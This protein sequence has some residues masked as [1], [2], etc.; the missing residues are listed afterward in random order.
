MIEMIVIHRNKL[1]QKYV[2]QKFYVQMDRQSK[3][4]SVRLIHLNRPIADDGGMSAS[5]TRRRRKLKK[6]TIEKASAGLIRHNA[7]LK[8]SSRKKP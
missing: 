5:N 1:K 4:S 7:I 2:K 3:K 8:E 6:H